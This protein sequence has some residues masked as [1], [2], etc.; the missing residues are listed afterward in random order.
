MKFARGKVVTGL[1]VNA[2]KMKLAIREFTWIETG[3]I[4]KIGF[5]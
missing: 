3:G 4:Q 5:E 2:L 1:L